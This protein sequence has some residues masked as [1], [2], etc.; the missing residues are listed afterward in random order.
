[1]IS[2]FCL[3]MISFEINNLSK[4]RIPRALAVQ[5]AEAVSAVAKVKQAD[6]SLAYI[7][8]KEMRRLNGSYRGKDKVT[9]VLSFKDTSEAWPKGG[10]LG[11]ILICPAQAKRQMKDF[12]TNFSQEISR[13]LIHGLAHL[14]G[15]DHENV[16]DRKVK[17]MELFERRCRDLIANP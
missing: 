9:D 6:F 16:G 3:Y 7:S 12:G 5:A 2:G 8:E 4:V 11:E 15:Y 1:M 13:L 17:Q 10:F 14:L